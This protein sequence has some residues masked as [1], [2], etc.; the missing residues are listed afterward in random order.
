M[1]VK[2]NERKYELKLCMEFMTRKVVTYIDRKSRDEWQ[3]L[4]EARC[5]K[6]YK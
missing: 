5:L 1:K 6:L 2:E 4:G 3:L